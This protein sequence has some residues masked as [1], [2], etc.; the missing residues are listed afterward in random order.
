[1]PTVLSKVRV[2]EHINLNPHELAAWSVLLS[3]QKLLLLY[4]LPEGRVFLLPVC[5]RP[6]SEWKRNNEWIFISGHRAGFWRLQGASGAQASLCGCLY[7]LWL[8]L[9]GELTPVV[10]HNHPFHSVN[11]SVKWNLTDWVRSN[12][13]N[14]VVVNE[15]ISSNKWCNIYIINALLPQPWQSV[16]L[17]EVRQLSSELKLTIKLHKRGSRRFSWVTRSQCFHIANKSLLSTVVALKGSQRR[18]C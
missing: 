1:M 15:L 14:S 3:R 7:K 6:H 13:L 11:N 5:F 4:E 18:V 9:N 2:R 10:S 17:F 16:C 8:T 12:T